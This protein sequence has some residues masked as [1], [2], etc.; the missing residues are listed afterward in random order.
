MCQ[1]PGDTTK[2]GEP[3]EVAMETGVPE[4]EVRVDLCGRV[5]VQL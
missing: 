5:T 2:T 3:F 4:T 1:L